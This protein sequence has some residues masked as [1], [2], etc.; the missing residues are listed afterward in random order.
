MRPPTLRSI[1]AVTL[2]LGLAACRVVTAPLPNGGGDLVADLIAHNDAAIPAELAR[3]QRDGSQPTFGGVPDA[4]GLYH[5]GAASGLIAKLAAAYVAPQSRFAGSPELL[6]ALDDAA[7][8]MLSAQHDDGTIDLLTTNFHSPPDTGFILEWMCAAAAVLQKAQMPAADLVLQKLLTFIRR[9]ADALAVGGIHTPNHRWVVCMA[10]A[11]ANALLPDARYVARIDTWLAE[12]IDID[13]DGQF[14]E[15]STAI[16]SPLTDRCL[17]TT[18]RLLDRP[19]LL[20][21]VRRNL[22]MSLYYR[23]AD[24]SIAT[25]GSRRQDQGQRGSMQSY[26]YPYR[27]MALHDGDGR[28]AAIA[29]QLEDEP[30]ANLAG[31]LIYFLESP[32]LARPLPA[33]GALPSDFERHF[34]HSELVRIRRGALSATILADNPSFFSLHVGSAAVVLR[35]AAAFFGKGQFV[36]EQLLEEGGAWVLRQE[37]TGPYYQP[38]DPALRRADGNWHAMDREQ[39]AL[40]EVQHLQSVVRI[41]E[42]PGGVDVELEITGTDGVPVAIEFSC[43]H[44]A[45]ITGA[46]PV[47]GDAGSWV[48]TGGHAV[49]TRGGDRIAIRAGEAAHRWVQIRG[50]LPKLPGQ[51]VYATGFTPLRRTLEFRQ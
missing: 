16:Y 34:P 25:E 33:A 5:A 18:A 15:R 49:V 6:A 46:A 14:T 48:M 38:I 44:A 41:R 32:E 23:H 35:F 37:L 24:G 11:R 51:S 2:G 20:E 10:L 21:P 3:Q 39:R 42:A 9:G 8:F 50:A 12:H 7:T 19:E 30:G 22:E 36:G 43:E 29:R 26:Y 31:Q 28:F 47:A 13:A 27:Y 17:I 40:S 4:Y 45:A 1:A